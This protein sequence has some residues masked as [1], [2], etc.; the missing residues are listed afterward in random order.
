MAAAFNVVSKLKKTKTK[1]EE[2]LHEQQQIQESRKLARQTTG[3]ETSDLMDESRWIKIFIALKEEG[4]I[5]HDEVPKALPMLGLPTNEQAWID[6]VWYKTTRFIQMN[7]GDFIKFISGY[8]D[9][10][11]QA[12]AEAFFEVDEGN[13]GEVEIHQFKDLLARFGIKPMQ[14]VL[15]EVIGEVDADGSGK[16]NLQ[17]FDVVMELIRARQ[18][19]TKGEWLE[20]TGVFQ[21]FDPEKRGEIDVR[22][23]GSIIIWLGYAHDTD[24]V[25]RIVRQVDFDGGG[26]LNT[27]EFLS[28][29]RKMREYEVLKMQ[30]IMRQMDTDGGGRADLEELRPILAGLGYAVDLAA[31]KEAATDAGLFDELSSSGLDLCQLW[32]LLVVFRK[33]EGFSEAENKDI[34]DAFDRYC[35]KS[36]TEISGT[37]AGKVL[38][39]LGYTPSFEVQ[40]RLVK[41]VDADASGKLNF[42]EFKK[43]VRMLQTHEIENVFKAFRHHDPNGTGFLPQLQAG[44]AFAEAGCVDCRGVTPQISAEDLMANLEGKFELSLDTFIR[45]ATQFLKDARLAFRENSGFSPQEKEQMEEY[46]AYYDT[47]GSGDVSARE[48]VLLITDLFPQMAHDPAMRP[49]L[50]ELLQGTT[51]LDFQEFLRLMQQLQELTIQERVSKEQD[52]YAETGFTMKEVEEFRELYLDKDAGIEEERLNFKRLERMLGA[53]FPLG[54]KNV[55]ELQAVVRVVTGRENGIHGEKVPSLDFPEFLRLMRTLEDID[56][57]GIKQI[58]A[59]DKS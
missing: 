41:R 42:Q 45:M 56:F 37:E 35:K 2:L 4:G 12:F 13:A 5:H 1:V 30:E 52:A 26:S 21:K 59:N 51:N 50:A 29:M 8:I 24:R 18:G 46:F 58:L 40:Q 39:W 47:D 20:M 55:A 17:E 32:Q 11:A 49:R 36:H 9:R 23:I 25:D 14:H 44:Y 7:Q 22:E 54:A 10:Q 34:K 53:I 31:V 6:E 16:I 3:K 19:F 28:L 27:M 33:R 43:V 38:R 15:D 48:I 57:G